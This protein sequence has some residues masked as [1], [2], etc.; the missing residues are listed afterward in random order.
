MVHF[1]CLQGGGGSSGAASLESLIDSVPFS[2]SKIKVV[3]ITTSRKIADNVTE[4]YVS[5]PE[6]ERDGYLY[7]IL[8][9]HPGRTIVFVNAISSVRRLAAVFKLLGMPVKG[10][11]A[12]MQ[13]RARMKALDK[14][15]EDSNAVLVATDVAA[16]GLDVKDVKCVIHYQI[17]AS[18]DTY[19]HR[20][21]RTARAEEDGIS[22]AFV[23]PQEHGRY[24][25]LMNSLECDGLQEFPVDIS[26]MSECR[27]RVR[28][29]VKYDSITRK[30]TK[31]KAEKSWRRINAEQVGIVL[32]DESEE[33]DPVEGQIVSLRKGK[34]T[35]K[36]EDTEQE[37]SHAQKIKAKLDGLLSQPLQ[38][39]FSQ[40]FFAGGAASGISYQKNASQTPTEIVSTIKTARNLASERR[41][42]DKARK[43]KHEKP[44]SKQEAL[45]A[46]VKKHIENKQMKKAGKL[47]RL[48]VA[49]GAYGRNKGG[50]TALQAYRQKSA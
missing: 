35:R 1:C 50:V 44:K 22:I 21:G 42:E 31:S 14:F 49:H 6:K 24:R 10:L 47:N 41:K 12:G 26:L 20:S 13:Q 29:A 23:T 11:H 15:R 43:G 48:V 18:V 36:S 39:K 2:S 37:K 38:P 34:R 30:E 4:S 45:A 3:D 25:A 16:R 19:V 28:L 9:A 8:A 33:D 46:A 40:K 27:E 7:C 5:C 17:P 32:S